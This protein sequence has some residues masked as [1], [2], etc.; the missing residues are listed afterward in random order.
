MKTWMYWAIGLA[1]VGAAS[2]YVWQYKKK[3]ETSSKSVTEK[4]ETQTA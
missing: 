4:T 2:Y 1:V 3:E